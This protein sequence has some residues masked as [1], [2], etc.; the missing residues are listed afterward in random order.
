MSTMLAA[1]HPVPWQIGSIESADDCSQPHNCRPKDSDCFL[2]SVRSQRVK[3]VEPLTD[4]ALQH[5]ENIFDNA[6][7]VEASVSYM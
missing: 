5:S 2:M 6:C 1:K 7:S 3:T 4:L